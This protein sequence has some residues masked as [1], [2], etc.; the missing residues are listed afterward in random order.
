[1]ARVTLLS[2]DLL[3]GS[4]VEGGL[5]AAGHEVE[6][7]W[8]PEQARAALARAD[9]LVVDLTH[10]D[11]DGAS[12][13]ESLKASGELDGRKTLGFYSHVEQETRRRADAAGFDLVVPRSRMAREM[14]ALV[15][16][17]LARP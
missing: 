7:V 11:Y 12:V 2:P 6:R 16:G 14:T 15:E 10:D 13:V 17:L 3:F 1:M 5:A 4:K 9:L 8:A